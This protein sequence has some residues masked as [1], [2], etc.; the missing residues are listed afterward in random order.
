MPE[1]KKLIPL[2]NGESHTIISPVVG[3]QDCPERINR[4]LLLVLAEYNDCNQSG[5]LGIQIHEDPGHY[6]IELSSDMTEREDI[7]ALLRIGLIEVA[8]GTMETVFPE[9]RPNGGDNHG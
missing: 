9:P 3:L 7:L 5:C 8:T 1:P 2:K 4:F 6:H